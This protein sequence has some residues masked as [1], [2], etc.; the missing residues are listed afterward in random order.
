MAVAKAMLMTSRPTL[1]D[2][3]ARA[4]VS[5]K[6][7]ARVVNREEHVSGPTREKVNRAVAELGYRANL[8]ARS[9]ASRRAYRVAVLSPWI[10]AY[11][12]SK[13]HEGASAACRKRGYQL[14]IQELDPAKD[15]ALDE[16]AS[17]LREQPL[18]GVF[19]PAPL[20]DNAEL[21]DLLDREAVRYV[22]HS[23]IS[24]PNRSDSVVADEKGGMEHLVGHL[25]DKGHRRFGVVVGPPGHLASRLRHDGVV[26][27]LARRGSDPRSVE[28]FIMHMRSPL[29]EQGAE[30]AERFLALPERSTAIL[31][32]NDFVA[33]GVLVQA[34]RQH[35]NVPAD[36]AVAGY[37]DADFTQFLWPPLT[38]IYQPN[39]EMASIAMD[40]L[41]SSP[42]ED[43]RTR[44]FPVRLE[45]RSST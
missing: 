45:I 7:V 3:A 42:A 30:A 35:V 10:S 39:L 23:P 38:T 4:G 6:T 11:F 27:A 14:A 16:F 20:C 36:L 22:R 8:S 1:A 25:W 40:W 43:V 21:L 15:G 19:L 9:L 2:V 44:T 37:D 29:H 26:E 17:S 12:V 13:M 32:Y 34:H 31:C 41:T 28:T 24:E 5:P 33:A 18:D